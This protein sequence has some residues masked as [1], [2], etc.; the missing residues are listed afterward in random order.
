V[1]F[2]PSL[3]ELVTV[4]FNVSITDDTAVESEEQFEV[5]LSTSQVAVVIEME[6][7]S[8]IVN[9]AD[10]DSKLY[11]IGVNQSEM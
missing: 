8:A 5:F 1:T 10:N 3:E 11:M 6:A 7:S 4:E 2:S 9:I